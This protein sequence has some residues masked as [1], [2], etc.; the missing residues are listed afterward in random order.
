MRALITFLFILGFGQIAFAQEGDVRGFVYDKENG[1]PILFANVY[2]GG[3]TYGATTDIN[4]FFNIAKVPVGDYI[5]ICEYVGYDSTGVAVTVEG[6]KITNQSLY[7]SE[8]ATDLGVVDVTAAKE[9]A[10]SDVRV[11]VTTITPKQIKSIPGTG[12]E[13][14]LAQYLQ[15]LPGVIFTGDQGGQLYIRGGSP[16]QNRILLDGMTIY[17]PFH[18]IGFFSVFETETIRNVDVLSGGFGADHGGRISSIID[19]TTRDGNKKRLSGIVGANPFQAKVILEGP[20]VKLD[21]EGGTSAS[22]LIT[23]KHSYLDQTSEALYSYVDS[24][25]LPYQ[26]TDIYG[27]VSLTS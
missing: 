12:G 5:L 26:Y 15:I 13:A 27:K 17:N 7:L 21:E 9:E 25:G 3:T 20:L 10:R 24:A 8:S 11:S 1:E 18:S 16:I 14:D 22:F 19:I 2:L 6:G 4:G 23:G